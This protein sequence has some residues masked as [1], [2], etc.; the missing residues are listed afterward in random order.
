MAS[1]CS[2]ANGYSKSREAQ[3]GRVQKYKARW[4]VRGF[5]QQERPNYDGT[6]AAVVKSMSYKAL[7]AI[8]AALDY[9][10][11]QMDVKTTYGDIEKEIYVEQLTGYEEGDGAE[12]V[13][14]LDKALYGLK[15]VPS[16]LV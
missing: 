13:C 1:V 8:A 5:E 4:V 12:D 3:N 16:Y 15:T 9:E 14:V 11:K 10:V 6:F 2:A 7:F